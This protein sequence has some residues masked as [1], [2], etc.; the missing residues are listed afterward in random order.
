MKRTT[1]FDNK[2]G[3]PNPHLSART[4]ILSCAKPA[5]ATLG[6]VAVSQGPASTNTF[7]LLVLIIPSERREIHTRIRESKVARYVFV[8]SYK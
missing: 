7:W 8:T 2:L 4:A 3:F 5:G 1:W 6:A